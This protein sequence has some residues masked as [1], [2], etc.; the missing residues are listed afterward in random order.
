MEMT[1]AILG[2]VLGIAGMAGVWL[3]PSRIWQL[4]VLHRVGQPLVR[5]TLSTAVGLSVA[6]V[7]LVAILVAATSLP[8]VFRCLWGEACGPSR[9]SGLIRLVF[10]GVAVVAVELI[11]QA[12]A[13][14]QRR[15]NNEHAV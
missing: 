7:L 1:V 3:V 6:A 12:G 13:Y 5:T 15:S 2:Y 8:L 4:V 10:F 14:L 9:G 11:W